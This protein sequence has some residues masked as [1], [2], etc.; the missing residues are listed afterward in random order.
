MKK[1]IVCILFAACVCLNL[2][3][4]GGMD[5]GRDN[6]VVDRPAAPQATTEVMPE[7]LPVPTPDVDDGV[8][9]DDDGVIEE[10]DT[11]TARSDTDK[12]RDTEQPASPAPTTTPTPGNG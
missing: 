12:T 9:K 3:A 10:R 2:C 7:I 4:C 11:G 5:T 6:A 8:V 1:T